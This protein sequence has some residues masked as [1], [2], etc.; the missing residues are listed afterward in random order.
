MNVFQA[1]EK[2]NVFMRKVF[3]YLSLQDLVICRT[4][5]PRFEHYAD[6]AIAAIDNLAVVSDGCS[7]YS[8]DENWWYRTKRSTCFENQI[9][10]P[11]FQSLPIKFD[12]LKFLHIDLRTAANITILNDLKQLVHLEIRLRLESDE[13]TTLDLPNLKVFVGKEWLCCF[14]PSY[15]LN[16]PNLEVLAFPKIDRVQVVNPESIKKLS[17]DYH[18]NEGVLERF[19]NLEAL[20]F[21]CISVDSKALALARLADLLPNWKDLK[22][23]HFIHV[24]LQ[25]ETLK[26]SLVKLIRRRRNMGREELKLYLNDALL[27]DAKQLIDN[28]TSNTLRNFQFKNYQLLRRAAYP[29]V[30]SVQFDELMEL[31]FGIS[32]DFFAKFPAIEVLRANGPVDQDDFEWFLKNAT[33]VTCLHLTNTSL[34]RTFIKDLPNINNRLVRLEVNDS[35]GLIVDFGFILQFEQLEIFK[36]NQPLGSLAL[37]AE[38]FTKLNNLC[39]FVFGASNE[40]VNIRRSKH[41]E[42]PGEDYKLVCFD[43]TTG[44]QTFRQTYASW[45]ELADSYAQRMEDSVPLGRGERVKRQKVA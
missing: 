15:V 16:C 14:D 35:P 42:D 8:I 18:G 7:K 31:T 27:L 32:N 10:W 38:A 25:E 33:A 19:K 4:V 26:S 1:D 12:Q 29:D 44:A 21:E 43:C 9:T 13:L 24:N 34:G 36:T 23:L 37:A 39:N 5:S 3:R 28:K 30:K 45:I 22:E 2:L 11:E 41:R 40:R 6:L 17:C 20:S